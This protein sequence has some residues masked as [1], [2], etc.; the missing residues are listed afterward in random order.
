MKL[1][2]WTLEGP[3]LLKAVGD[4]GDDLSDEEMA[5][6]CGYRSVDDF[7]QA[8][9]QAEKETTFNSEGEPLPPGGKGYIPP[10]VLINGFIASFS[11]R[12]TQVYMTKECY[13]KKYEGNEEFEELNEEES[14]ELIQ[15]FGFDQPMMEADIEFMY[16][17]NGEIV[18]C[19][20]VLNFYKIKKEDLDPDSPYLKS[21]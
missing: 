16:Y 4:V 20:D 9:D 6:E 7:H 21:C 10:Y 13:E 18:E 8:V 14:A 17:T 2:S 19:D 1:H 5:E 15:S 12:F 11:S 3:Y